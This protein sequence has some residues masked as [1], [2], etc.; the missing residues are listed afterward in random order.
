MHTTNEKNGTIYK[1]EED[2]DVGEE[3][4]KFINGVFTLLN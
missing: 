3:I 4:G 1:K 2:G